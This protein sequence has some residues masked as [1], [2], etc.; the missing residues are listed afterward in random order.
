MSSSKREK[1]EDFGGSAAVSQQLL[2]PQGS[3]WYKQSFRS[4]GT[5]G[6]QVRNA[7]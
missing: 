2:D 4:S 6:N 3:T 7:T 5:A 1:A